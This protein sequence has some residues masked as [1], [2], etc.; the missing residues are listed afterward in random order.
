MNAEERAAFEILLATDKEL[1]YELE[2][3][4]N[5][6]NA[7]INAGMKAEFAKAIRQKIIVR[8]FIQW[9]SILLVA[10]VVL[11]IFIFRDN[12]FTRRAKVEESKQAV[13]LSDKPFI[14]PPSA[15]INIPYS[16]Y[17]LDAA[18]GDTIY[19]PSGSILCFPA[20]AFVDGSGNI[21]KGTVNITYR[22][23]AD[24]IDFFVSGV[25]MD[26]D[27]AGVKYNFESSGMCEINAYKDNKPIFVNQQAQPQINLSTNN[28]DPKHN[29]Y[30]LDTVRRNWKFIGKDK[31]TEVKDLVKVKTPEMENISKGR[32]GNVSYE[33]DMNDYELLPLIPKP[34]KAT[35]GR[36]AFSIEIE[37]GSFEEL[38]IYN[39]QKFEVIDETTYKR[40]DADEHW[41][42]MKLDKSITEGIY[43]VTFTN[44]RRTVAYKVRP[45][46]SGT[47]Y[48]AALKLFNE[49][50]QVYD[51]KKNNRIVKE[52]IVA[53]SIISS[54][55]Q[56]DEKFKADKERNEE[57]N[58]LIIARNKKLREM[59]QQQKETLA[60]QLKANED[61]AKEQQRIWDQQAEAAKAQQLIFEK[62]Q[63]KFEK[64]NSLSLEIVRT[65][66]ITSFGYW[67]CDRPQ[68]PRELITIQAIFTYD[69]NTLIL[70]SASVAYRGFNG[71]VP[72]AYLAP[73][74]VF[75]GRENMILGINDGLFYYFSYKNFAALG[76]T[77][78]TKKV[79]FN[80]Q[81]AEKPFSSYVDIR[82]FIERL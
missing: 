8:R 24:P 3:Q 7:A 38:F 69:N 47:D 62:Q 60:K 33:S 59:Q 14:T 22:E 74:R 46:L 15:I 51:Q 17:S 6:V 32:A 35:P 41:D 63:Q 40:S 28:R 19:Y 20:N 80:M 21:I 11:L 25:P 30:Y 61:A 54:N 64:D 2:V 55:K 79:T 65:F 9:G 12:I 29:L 37:P 27:S 70:P 5:I 31:I 71:V 26:Y 42:N 43:I 4:R 23:F 56:A 44:T 1:Q 77:K 48:D 53:D 45:V 67:N 13:I 10:I 18:K 16:E 34:I 76:I 68:Y 75:T 57:L 73:I 81:R 82:S 50:N 72:F 36:Q 49:K 58:R 52:K 78:D 66:G 39:K